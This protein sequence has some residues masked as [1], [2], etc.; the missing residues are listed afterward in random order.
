MTVK[1]EKMG[2]RKLLTSLQTTMYGSSLNNAPSLLLCS[3]CWR[4]EDTDFFGAAVNAK[5]S[6]NVTF[7]S[8]PEIF[9]LKLKKTVENEDNNNTVKK[10]I[11]GHKR[12]A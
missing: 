3:S 5:L 6:I 11:Y 10:N 7:L 1:L 9:F 2:S 8:T 4:I 12:N